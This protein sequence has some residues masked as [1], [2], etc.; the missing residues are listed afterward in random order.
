MS[1]EGHQQIN[2]LFF[3]NVALGTLHEDLRMF[4]CCQ[5]C[6][7]A[8][9]ALLCHTQYFCIADSDMELNNTHIINCCISTATMVM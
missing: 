2:I 6:I 3:F 4:Y 9:R 7:F 1:K 5:Q 8:I